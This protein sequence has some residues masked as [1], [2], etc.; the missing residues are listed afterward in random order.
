MKNLKEK[1]SLY[2]ALAVCLMAVGIAAFG[3]YTG[4]STYMS[5]I[6][7]PQQISQNNNEDE[8]TDPS[9]PKNTPLP[10]AQPTPSPTLAP[11]QT[12]ASQQETQAPVVASTPAPDT[13]EPETDTAN[14]VPYTLNSDYTLPIQAGNISAVFSDGN[15]VYNDTMKDWRTHNGM[16]FQANI[17]DPVF[18]CNNGVVTEVYSDLLLGNV[19]V[20][21]HGQYDFYYCGLGDTALVAVGDV[22]SSATTLGSVSTVPLEA[23]STHLHLEVKKDGSYINPKSVLLPE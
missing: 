12:P 1:R 9:A 23:N 2:L 4:V 11:T 22:V 15:L 13:V 5:D 7:T 16:D 20:V 10:T 21:E 3:T 18:A 14:A 17:G 6:A 19:V 8:D